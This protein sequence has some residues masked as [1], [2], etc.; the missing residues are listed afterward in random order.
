MLAV[1]Y[2][3]MSLEIISVAARILTSCVS[4]LSRVPNDFRSSRT[5]RLHITPIKDDFS[6]ITTLMSNPTLQALL[7][8]INFIKLSSIFS[9]SIKSYLPNTMLFTN[10]IASAL[11]IASSLAAPLTTTEVV[12]KPYYSV[13]LKHILNSN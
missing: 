9:T 7:I 4:K 10:I 11:L 1:S 13:R 12:N 3:N 8:S 5:R 6:L 2:E